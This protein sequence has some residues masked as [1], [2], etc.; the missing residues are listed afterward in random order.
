MSSTLANIQF[1]DSANTRIFFNSAQIPANTAWAGFST[2][3]YPDSN[4]PFFRIFAGQV[5]NGNAFTSTFTFTRGGSVISQQTV[6]WGTDAVFNANGPGLNI[7][8]FLGSDNLIFHST[9]AVGCIII[10][11]STINLG[12]LYGFTTRWTAIC[13]QI[14]VVTNPVL[15]YT[16]Q[17]AKSEIIHGGIQAPW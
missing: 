5:G 16:N 4:C 2:T 11:V 12:T 13:D 6:G 7:C 9:Y 1:T 10:G 3:Y 8:P 15:P 14:K 17:T